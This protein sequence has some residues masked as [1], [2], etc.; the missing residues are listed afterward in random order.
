MVGRFRSHKLLSFRPQ[1]AVML[2]PPLLI[3]AACIY[4]Y[5]YLGKVEKRLG[6]DSYQPPYVD[7]SINIDKRK[8][9]DKRK[10]ILKLPQNS[11]QS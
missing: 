11:R 10:V 6:G 5:W 3:V 9:I 7:N 1:T 2:I 8:Y 4:L